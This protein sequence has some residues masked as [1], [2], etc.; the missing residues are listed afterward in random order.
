MK[1]V[2]TANRKTLEFIQEFD[3]LKQQHNV[4]PVE[5]LFRLLK[6]RKQSIKIQA[7]R[8][9]MT[10][11]YPKLA[12]AHIQVDGPE[13]IEMR[14]QQDSEDGATGLVIDAAPSDEIVK[15]IEVINNGSAD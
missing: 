1:Q 10:Y 14:W 9:L 6:S 7:A 3:R 15:E 2:G 8:E 4:D 12:A 5:V 11:R 13:Q